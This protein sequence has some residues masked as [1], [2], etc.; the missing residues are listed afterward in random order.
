MRPPPPPRTPTPTEH[1][2]SAESSQSLDENEEK[3]HD[4]KQGDNSS[5]YGI[6]SLWAIQSPVFDEM[7]YLSEELSKDHEKQTPIV[8]IKNISIGA[9]KVFSNLFLGGDL[10]V[11]PH[12]LHGLSVLFLRW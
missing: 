7:L 2:K 3:E 1:Q 6:K 10:E 8:K 12:L 5:L 11:S 4:D 9:M